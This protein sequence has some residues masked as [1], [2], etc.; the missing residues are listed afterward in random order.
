[1]TAAPPDGHKNIE[2]EA[3]NSGSQTISKKKAD[4]P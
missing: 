1:M 4:L 2:F 3:L